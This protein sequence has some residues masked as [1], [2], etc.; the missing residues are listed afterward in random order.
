MRVLTV[1]LGVLTV[2][3]LTSLAAPARE[4]RA[5]TVDPSS[6]AALAQMPAQ[7]SDTEDA[8]DTESSR[9]SEDGPALDPQTEA[10]AAKNRSKI[11]V[12]IIAA[13]LLGIVVWGRYVRAKRAKSG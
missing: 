9:S 2:V 8:G 13:A 10:D 12:G 3:L 1:L 7:D 6:G 11:V 4:A 5:A